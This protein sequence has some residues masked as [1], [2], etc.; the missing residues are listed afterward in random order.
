MT[1][2]MA[3]AIPLVII[4]F[5]GVVAVALR[6]AARRPGPQGVPGSEPAA[7]TVSADEGQPRPAVTTGVRHGAGR[8]VTGP[9]A[10]LAGQPVPFQQ[11]QLIFHELHADGRNAVCAVCDSQYESA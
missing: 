10:P 9:P 2:P 1:N 3:P 7:V 6:A 4:V 11:A 8:E 5:A